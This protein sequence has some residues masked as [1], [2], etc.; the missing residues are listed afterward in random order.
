MTMMV[1]IKLPYRS[2]Y[3]LQTEKYSYLFLCVLPPSFAPALTA[4][5]QPILQE[6]E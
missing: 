1:A 4:E 2:L 3:T 6:V 5:P